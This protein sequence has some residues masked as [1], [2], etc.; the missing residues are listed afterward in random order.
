[1]IYTFGDCELDTRL[2]ELRRAG[3]PVPVEPQ[4]FEVLAFLVENRDR[5]VAKQELLDKVWPER[6]VGEAALNSRVMSARKAIGD[7]GKEQRLIKTVHGRGYR[8]VGEVRQANGAAEAAGTLTA[9]GRPSPAQPPRP[10]GTAEQEI[11]FCTAPDGVRIAYALVGEGPPL[12]KA[13]NW[14]SHLEFEWRSPL[15]RHSIEQLSRD[16][17]YIRWDQRGCGLS[18]WDVEDLSLSAWVSDLETVA[19]ELELERFPLLGISQGGAVAITYAARHPERVSHL[20]L[21]GAFARGRGKRPISDEQR[22]LNEAI[23]TLARHGWGKDDPAY[24]QMFA[25]SFIPGATL[26]QMRWFNDICRIST[27]PEN[28]ARYMLASNEIDVADLLGRVEAPTL[29]LHARDERRVPFD[30]GRLL[31]AGIRG[32]RF[33][34]LESSNHLLLENEPAWGVFLSEVRAF[35]GVGERAATPAESSIHTILFTDV[36]GSTSLTQRLGDEQARG[37]MREH[38]RIVRESLA[39]HGGEEVKA[40][41][42][43]FMVTFSSP[44]R[45]LECAI[46]IQKGCESA[47]NGV[48]VRIGI[49]AGEP[50]REDEDLFGTSVNMAAR[51]AGEA[52][53]GEILVSDVVRQ[54]VAGKGFMFSDRG[55]ADLRG[56]DDPV[57][58]FE[59]RWR[60]GS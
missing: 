22:E 9:A 23:I 10:S 19:D 25:T 43:G 32:A 4:V 60:N 35:L 20:I 50:I 54:L 57:P 12:V 28:A 36:E 8:F 59:V 48:K 33:V 24:R 30:E 1:V 6:F 2:F 42:D 53:G 13:P 56:F 58:L 37:L 7:S 34:P 29:V 49:N 21:Y 39:Q 31:A 47:A 40:L 45:A 15:W 3:S 11:R 27:S 38:E 52:N 55:P 44:T 41:G 46:A 18:D 17:Q 16:H 51:I 5:V 26:E 14:M